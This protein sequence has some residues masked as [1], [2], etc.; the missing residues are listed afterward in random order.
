[1]RGRLGSDAA[2][3]DAQGFSGHSLERRGV[4]RR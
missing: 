4:T 3:L 2:D 1:M